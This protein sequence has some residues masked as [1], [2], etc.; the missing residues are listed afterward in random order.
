LICVE[1]VLSIKKHW[2]SVYQT[3]DIKTVS[4][5]Q[6]QETLS[7]KLI[8]DLSLNKSAQIIDIGGGASTLVDELIFAGYENLSVLDI[9]QAALILDRNRLGSDADKVTWIESDI[10]DANLPPTYYELWH[11]RAA[12]HFL[13]DPDHRDRYLTKART[14]ISKGG[15][16][17]IATFANDGPE[18]CSGLPVVRYSEAKLIEEF[19]P[20]FE[21][22]YSLKEDHLTPAQSVQK[23][24]YCLFQ[25]K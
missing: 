2:E 15:Y 6:P 19:T 5:F 9:S 22:V 11:D 20:S 8:N 25:R 24:I 4:W 12:F 10:L 17:L 23:F 7:L 21:F 14:S 1:V 18:Q 16:L 13:T 3:K